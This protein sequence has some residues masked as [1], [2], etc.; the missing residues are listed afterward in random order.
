LHKVILVLLEKAVQM[1]GTTLKDFK[2]AQG[3]HGLFQNASQVYGRASE[4]CQ[5]CAR[6]IRRIVQGQRATYYC[7]GCQR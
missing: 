5:V 6:P 1:G 7:V 4:P 2:N 3:E